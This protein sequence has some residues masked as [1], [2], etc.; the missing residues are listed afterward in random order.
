MR[1]PRDAFTISV[2]V[3]TKMILCKHFVISTNIRW[4][5]LLLCSLSQ[6]QKKIQLVERILRRVFYFSHFTEIVKSVFEEK[7]FKHY[8]VNENK[9]RRTSK[10][11]NYFVI[12]G[13]HL[14][15]QLY[16]YSTKSAAKNEI[17]QCMH[18]LQRLFH[19]DKNEMHYLNSKQTF[20][21]IADRMCN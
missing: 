1:I 2:I 4:W 10:F 20:Q 21:V 7:Y 5:L 6:Q 14:S 8:V 16:Q 19:Q 9:R 12:D 13:S 3:I 15:F 17:L 11:S 18:L